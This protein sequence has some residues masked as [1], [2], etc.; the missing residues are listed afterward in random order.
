MERIKA[1]LGAEPGVLG[2]HFEGPFLLPERAGVHDPRL[3]RRPEPADLELLKPVPGGVT[4]VTVA[5]ERMAPGYI[6]QLATA[7]TR[8]SLGH[9]DGHSRADEG[10]YF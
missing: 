7:A 4:L 5:P 8:V 1:V 9:S 2:I 3:F 6:R 10:R